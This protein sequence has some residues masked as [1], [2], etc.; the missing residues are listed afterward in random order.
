MN[1][2]SENTIYENSPKKKNNID[3][4]KDNDNEKDN[5]NKSKIRKSLKKPNKYILD[6]K[7]DFEIYT[8]KK[9]KNK[10]FS[11]ELLENGIEIEKC[12]I[13]SNKDAFKKY[14]NKLKS[15]LHEI[16]LMI[17]PSE[18]KKLEKR[19]NM[20]INDFTEK[21]NRE[22]NVEDYFNG[23]PSLAEEKG[24]I[25]FGN[26][27]LELVLTMM[28]G[29]RNSINSIGDNNEMFNLGKNKENK[30]NKDAFKDFNCFNFVQNNFECEYVI[31]K[32]IN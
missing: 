31:N 22:I 9:I 19:Q 28:I 20:V 11:D 12:L 23:T 30:E 7:E 21:E 15:T 32:S 3:S 1:L 17:L 2:K 6:F 13:I 18:A 29:I 24:M 16:I 27:N 26:K 25:H 8:P 10:E 5:I 14:I 4:K